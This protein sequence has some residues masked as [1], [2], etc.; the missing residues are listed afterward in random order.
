MRMS[1]RL[2]ILAVAAVAILLVYLR[3]KGSLP[4]PGAIP[5]TAPTYTY[6]I[7]NVYPHDPEAFTQGLVF[8]QGFLYEGTGLRGR[9][10][11][12]RVDPETGRVL[13]IHRLADDLFGEGIT[14]YEDQ[15]F[16]LTY[17]SRRGFVYRKES[18]ELLREFT[19][20]TFG[21]GLTQDGSHLIMSDGTSM[22]YFLNPRG[23]GRTGQLLVKD[24]KHP[25]IGLNEL[26]YINGEIYANVW[27]TDLIARISPETGQV[28]GWIDLTGL[29]GA[30]DRTESTDVLNGIAYDAQ[31]HRLFV[32]GKLWPRL[33][34]IQVV[35]R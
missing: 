2:T 27:R 20:P 10:S 19:Y 30:A 18:L 34:E 35:R 12:R 5:R 33:F 13:D 8:D 6:R 23:M 14:I 7:V 9:S 31:G 24:G 1:R 11:L 32:T 25:V 21:W 16:Q 17:A 3:W 29:L 15:I 4:T 26:E 28:L 22:L